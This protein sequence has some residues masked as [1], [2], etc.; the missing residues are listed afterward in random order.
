[1]L[2]K[3]R[4]YRPCIVVL[5]IAGG[6]MTI[7]AQFRVLTGLIRDKITGMGVVNALVLNYST[8]QSVYSDNSGIF[9]LE[10]NIGDTVVL[11]AVGYYYDR[12][13]VNDSLPGAP[14]PVKFIFTPRA[15]EISEARI[16]GLGTYDD[17]RNR[18]LELQR[19]KTKIEILTENLAGT[20]LIEAKDAYNGPPAGLAVPI[21]S[22][23][24]KERIALKK[25]MEKE[26]IKEQVYLKFNPEVIKKLT[27][28][29]DD[30]D[31]L[32]F[33]TFCDFSDEYLLEINEYDLAD[34]IVLK[35]EDFKI[36]RVN[37][38]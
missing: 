8:R 18:F 6:C 24:E 25:I 28:L 14:V 37:I 22:P 30:R 32:E 23:E 11:S 20:S 27:G 13:V 1:M 36:K 9:N 16:I 4:I 12:L 38:F 26:K 34:L 33:L 35:F 29:T 21:R 7:H 5:L 15:Y 10:I 19:P 31:I 3:P 2:R 17:F